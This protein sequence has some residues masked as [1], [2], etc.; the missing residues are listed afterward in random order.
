MLLDALVYIDQSSDDQATRADQPTAQ[1]EKLDFLMNLEKG[2]VTQQIVQVGDGI[3]EAA[4]SFE[5]PLQ[6]H[7][8]DLVIG[9][10]SVVVVHCRPKV[11][12][13]SLD[14]AETG[15]H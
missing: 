6:L 14:S 10:G 13:V 5:V 3:T 1:G 15:A 11:L 4:C 12:Q 7:Q 8:L 2:I 9:A